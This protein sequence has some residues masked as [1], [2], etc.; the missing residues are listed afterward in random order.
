VETEAPPKEETGY[1]PRPCQAFFRVIP[2]PTFRLDILEQVSLMFKGMGKRLKKRKIKDS[3]PEKK[4][5]P[6]LFHG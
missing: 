5:D 2:D 1:F 3:K 6:L 4:A